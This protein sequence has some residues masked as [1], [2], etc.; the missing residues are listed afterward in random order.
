ML[1]AKARSTTPFVD[2]NAG[3]PFV[4]DGALLDEVDAMYMMDGLWWQAG[5][6]DVTTCRAF[7]IIRMGMGLKECADFYDIRPEATGLLIGADRLLPADSV[8]VAL[9]EA[10]LGAVR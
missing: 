10:V 9:C 1:R 6:F 2:A 8:D 4:R 7:G 5:D 3:F